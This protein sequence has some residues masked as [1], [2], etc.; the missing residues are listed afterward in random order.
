M[1][2]PL[3]D[4]RGER[5]TETDPPKPHCFVADID[6]TFEQQ[7]LDLAQRQRITDVHH[8]REANYLG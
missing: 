5:R 7:I 3:P 1:N 4:F 6:T 8:H 2:A